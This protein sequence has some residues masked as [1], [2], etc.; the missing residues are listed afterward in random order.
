MDEELV[1]CFSCVGSPS[2]AYSSRESRVRRAKKARSGLRGSRRGPDQQGQERY[3][4]HAA[5]CGAA[6][7]V[8]KARVREA[9]TRQ[10][11]PQTRD[12]GRTSG[13]LRAQFSGPYQGCLAFSRQSSSYHDA[14][15][16][17]KTRCPTRHY[18][19][20]ATSDRLLPLLPIT[21]WVLRLRLLLLV[22]RLSHPLHDLPLEVR[23]RLD[24]RDEVLR[25]DFERVEHDRQALDAVVPRLEGWVG[26]Q[27]D[28]APKVAADPGVR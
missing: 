5:S 26:R 21:L 17:K 20:G 11:E 22:P 15:R 12:L 25:R 10:F 19:F 6:L 1:E 7:A 24:A 4:C 8:R 16:C 2:T 3:L 23:V 14:V 18:C 13:E 28:T 9:E 27:G